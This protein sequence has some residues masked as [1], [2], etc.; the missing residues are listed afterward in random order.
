MMSSPSAATK[1]AHTCFSSES[2]A[3]SKALSRRLPAT[4]TRSRASRLP[5]RQFAG[6]GDGEF[7]AAFVSL[8]GLADHQRGDEGFVERPDEGV[9]EA[10]GFLFVLDREVECFLGAAEFDEGRDGVQPVRVFVRLRPQRLG[11]GRHRRQL[12]GELL[13]VGAIAQGRHRAAAPSAP[14]GRCFPCVCCFP[15]V[16][17]PTARA[18]WEVPLLRG[19]LAVFWLMTRTRSSV[20]WIS[21][22]ATRPLDQQVTHGFGQGHLGEGDGGGPHPARAGRAGRRPRR[23]R[24][25]GDRSHRRG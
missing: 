7:D 23:C 1:S 2:A 18:A 14:R 11:Q 16:L 15:C 5:G 10:L 6:G 12:P 19:W 17:P 3:A 24:G 4:V 25:R 8:G 9:G 20:R 21:S 13:D 22:T